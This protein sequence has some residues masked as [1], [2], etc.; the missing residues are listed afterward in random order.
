MIEKLIENSFPSGLSYD[1]AAQ[2]CLRLYSTLDGVP[3]EFHE[4]CSKDALSAAFAKLASNGFIQ[5]GEHDAAYYGAN[6][7]GIN[8]KGHWAEV[9]ASIFR[10]GD[11]VDENL[12]S[13]LVSCLTNQQGLRH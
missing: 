12:G 4:E 3:D 2:L 1:S 5:E 8:D 9:I 6:F 11:T 10:R 7:H 13:Q